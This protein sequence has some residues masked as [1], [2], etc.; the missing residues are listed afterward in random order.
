MK[1][2]IISKQQFKQIFQE[3]FSQN[4]NTKIYT[5][6]EQVYTDTELGIR[7]NNTRYILSLQRKMNQ[8]TLEQFV[9]KI[10]FSKA[11]GEQFMPVFLGGENNDFIQPYL[12]HKQRIENCG[13]NSQ[14][15]YKI[16]NKLLHTSQKQSGRIIVYNSTQNLIK[17]SHT[18]KVY[19]KTQIHNEMYMPQAELAELL[20][21]EKYHKKQLT[22]AL[23]FSKPT[24][25]NLENFLIQN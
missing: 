3:N 18:K 19:A 24:I 9:E 2:N 1:S 23:E 11:N 14:N 5:P 20:T 8:E 7:I 10:H 17:I 12:R 13:H 21:Q 6:N 25:L 22:K 4:P 15:V 16:P